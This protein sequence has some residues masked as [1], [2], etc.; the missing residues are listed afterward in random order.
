MAACA[1][2]PRTP[3]DR[4]PMN[5]T[6]DPPP[7]WAYPDART[8]DVVDDYHGTEVADPY[9][10][11][12]N[13]DADDTRAW[14][15]TENQLTDTYLRTAGAR[16]VIKKRLTD[17]WDFERFGSPTHQNG[18]YF[19]SHN[20]GLQNQSVLNWSQGLDGQARVLL[21]PNTWSED[22][23]VSLKSW[24][25]S[26]DGSH[27]AYGISDAGSDW[28][29]FK[30]RN[31]DSG[32]DLPETLEWIKFTSASWLP[33]G[34]GFYYSAY[35]PPPAGEV[36]KETN[37]DQEIFFHRL[38]TPQSDDTLIYKRPD[39]PRWG[40]NGSVSE[41][42]N[43]L[44]IWVWQG[45]DPKNAIFYQDLSSGPDPDTVELLPEFDASYEFLGNIGAE[46]YFKTDM[47][48]PKGRIISVSTANHD[49]GSWSVIIG[50]SEHVLEGVSMVGGKF[51]CEYLQ[52]AKSVVK[53]YTTDGAFEKDLDLPGLGSASVGGGKS[54][55]TQLFYSY[56]SYTYPTSIF[57]YDIATATSTLW[58]Q[59]AVAFD[60]A[61]F[62]VSQV[63]YTSKDGTRV[64][65]FISHKKGIELT[66]N[67]PTLLYGYGGFNISLTPYFSLSRLVWMEL[68]GVYAVANLRGGNEYGEEWHLAGTKEHKQNVFD[69]FI[70]AGEYLIDQNYT[71]TSKLG[72]QGRSN[73]GLLVGAVLTQRPDLWGAALPGVGVLDMLRFHKFTIG[74][75][76]TSDYGD[77]DNP[78]EFPALHAYSPYHNIT[79]G[80]EYPP[81][82]VTTGDHDDRVF[83]AHSFK[84]AARLQKAQAS[85]NPILIRIETRAGHGGG[86]PTTLIIDQITDEWGF[87]LKTLEMT[88]PE[89]FGE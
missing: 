50:E 55:D 78:E 12:E 64:P 32:Q 51:F 54:T 49:R 21:D 28:M 73:G 41:D 24:T 62:E 56:S 39:N 2:T 20:S 88:V 19:F 38:N 26:E 30:I 82:M 66:G 14:I 13:L 6:N 33:D 65:M 58:K 9:R 70:A 80:I 86:T 84:F 61:D 71:K 34:S 59:P 75:A 53:I 43:Y 83:P 48:A 60:P 76:W 36:L 8:V 68:G 3:T 40:L 79:P 27:I 22:G 7:A 63:F 11:M 16:E 10:W 42:G 87:L 23:T 74:W 47:D 29:T 35:D 85:K 1:T 17:L 37:E 45:T 52:D 69:D 5:D 4:D 31:V 44:V 89:D 46:F 25:V 57:A 72:I 15:A 77:P 67:N 18:R 81:T